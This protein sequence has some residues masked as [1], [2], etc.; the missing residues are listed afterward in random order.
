MQSAMRGSAVYVGDSVEA[1]IVGSRALGIQPVYIDRSAD[2]VP[3]PGVLV[4][5]NLTHLLDWLGIDAWG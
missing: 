2:P 4:I 1:D 3:R 5:T